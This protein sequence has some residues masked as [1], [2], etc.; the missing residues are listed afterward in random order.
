MH[1]VTFNTSNWSGKMHTLEVRDGVEFDLYGDTFRLVIEEIA[2][3]DP[4]P[5]L[6]APTYRGATH[7]A[8]LVSDGW[9]YPL[10][11]LTKFAGDEHWYAL[12]TGVQRE[13]CDPVVAACQVLFM[14]L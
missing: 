9:D 3:P 6:E 14:I 11:K 8:K 1:T 7:S 13:D 5:G 10:V 12:G 2:D 4:I